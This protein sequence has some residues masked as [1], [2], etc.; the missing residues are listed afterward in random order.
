VVLG[1]SSARERNELAAQL[2]L[3][4]LSGELHGTGRSIVALSNVEADPV[5]MRALICGKK[6]KAYVAERQAAFPLGL[7]GQPSYLNDDIDG[8]VYE[9]TDLGKIVNV[10][11][12]RP[13]P[14]FLPMPVAAAD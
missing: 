11:V 12:P 1:G 10:P 8:V 3:R 9:A 7:K 5:D 2:L 6:A 4:G 13:R 14:Q